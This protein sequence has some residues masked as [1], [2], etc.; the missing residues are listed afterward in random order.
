MFASINRSLRYKIVAVIL[1][2]TLAALLVSTVALLS[3]EARNFRQFLISDA[4]TQADIVART[5]V[6]ALEFND[7]DAA[8]GNLSLLE[9]RASVIAAAIYES[10]GTLFAKYVRK[11]QQVQFPP[12]VSGAGTELQGDRLR[13]FHPIIH[14]DQLLGTVFL[15]A[16]NDL[17]GRLKG[18]LL[19][20]G[21]VM[22]VSLLVAAVISLRLQRSVSAPVL[23][24]TEVARQVI[25]NRDFTLRAAKTT[26]DEIGVLVDSFNGMLSEV[27][28]TT[29]ALRASNRRLQRET[30]ERRAAEAAL[31]L[32]DRR[33]DEFLATLAHELR[34]PLAP[35]VNALSMLNRD[36]ASGATRRR[37]EQILGRQ[38]AHLVRLVDDL[39]DV[40]RITRGKL[41]LNVES[42]ELQTVV[43]SA[44]DTVQLLMDSR[45]HELEV[46][47]PRETIHLRADSVRLSQVLS[48]LLN[49]A[50]KY[51]EPG[52]HVRLTAK[53]QDG[54]VEITV[55]DD[56]MGIPPETLPKIF[57]MFT[58]G[59][60]SIER[61]QGG[62]GVGLALTKRLIELHGGR[63]TARSEGRARGATFVVHLPTIERPAPPTREAASPAVA[64]SSQ[65]LRI[66][67]VDDNVDFVTSLALLLEESGHEVRI[68]HDAG[69]ALEAAAALRPEIAFLDLGLP[70]ISGYE[71]ARRLRESSAGSE[72]VLVALSGWGQPQDRA[73][74]KSAGFSRHLVKPVEF[75]QI[76]S[77]LDTLETEA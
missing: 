6:P 49:N 34:N 56:G 1:A 55:A 62:L 72:T 5:S 15:L 45:R 74:S 75:E 18:Y 69:T 50:A 61:A 24:V 21:G 2:T 43:G 41:D 65:A 12:A 57:Q 38:L 76:L 46:E 3:Y 53:P 29:E 25:E 54:H 16:T 30:E 68:A 31:R 37:A 26:N 17:P 64:K 11:G 13:L 10:D 9:G 44:V 33:K 51:T 59:D 8:A 60:G 52:G 71:L 63:I 48:N 47:L 66:L 27:G 22:L 20:L 39:L 42:V 58:Q 73:R 19:I 67:L 32:A 7:P 35:M 77:V 40:S 70:G 4:T 14:N 28:E 23:A 36:D